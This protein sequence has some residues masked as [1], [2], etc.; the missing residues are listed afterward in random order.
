MEQGTPGETGGTELSMSSGIQLSF[1]IRAGGREGAIGFTGLEEASESALL[2]GTPKFWANEGN[3]SHKQERR[4]ANTA[5]PS[6]VLPGILAST[7]YEPQRV[8]PTPLNIANL[9]PQSAIVNAQ[10]RHGHQF[11]LPQCV[12]VAPNIGAW[13]GRSATAQGC[14]SR[15]GIRSRSALKC[16]VGGSRCDVALAN[17]G[18]NQVARGILAILEAAIVGK[19]NRGRSGQTKPASHVDSRRNSENLSATTTRSPV[20]GA[21]IASGIP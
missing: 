10:V 17:W 8:A 14:P 3:G 4:K 15:C 5:M 18:I 12:S 20:L 6:I 13:R 16:T 1:G 11:A 9:R 2:L 7:P 19:P 21:T